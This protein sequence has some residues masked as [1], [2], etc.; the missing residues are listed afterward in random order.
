MIVKNL[1]TICEKVYPGSNVVSMPLEVEPEA[2]SRITI[3]K[4]VSDFSFLTVFWSMLE[5]G[6]A[7]DDAGSLQCFHST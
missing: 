4:E 5:I 2:Y 3:I 7:G 6:V 1:T